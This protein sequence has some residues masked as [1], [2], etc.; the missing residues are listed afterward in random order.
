MDKRNALHFYAKGLTTKSDNGFKL[1]PEGGNVRG[2]LFH[3]SGGVGERRMGEVE[4]RG[5]HEKPQ[6]VADSHAQL[7]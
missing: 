7:H 2:D 4:T 5:K 3:V 1:S 6:S